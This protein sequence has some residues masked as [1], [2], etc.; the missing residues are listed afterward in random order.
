MLAIKRLA[1]VA[2]DVDLEECTL[3]LSL[4]KQANEAEQILALK[5]RGDVTRNQS[6]GTSGPKIDLLLET[7]ITGVSHPLTVIFGDTGC[8]TCVQL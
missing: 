1:G 3:Q 7:L 4:Q 2:P 5:H 8:C 6:T